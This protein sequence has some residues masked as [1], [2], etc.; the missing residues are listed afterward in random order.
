MNK[1]DYLHAGSLA[2]AV[3]EHRTAGRELAHGDHDTDPDESE[4][5][6]PAEAR[7][8]MRWLPYIAKGEPH[9][10]AEL[11]D[12]AEDAAAGTWP[13]LIKSVS[14]R[15][16]QLEQWFAECSLWAHEAL[17]NSVEF[18]P[19]RRGGVPVLKGTR[20]TVAQTLAE[21]ADSAGVPEV[22]SEFDLD[23]E[24]IR[25]LLYGLALLAEKPPP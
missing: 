14:I 9:T 23:E 21:L 22:A 16:V 6:H 8:A 20:F 7:I 13:A 3:L 4:L 10:D 15:S 19:N 17:Q 2:A 12:P 5:P 18:D 11:R 1:P 25:R 24:T